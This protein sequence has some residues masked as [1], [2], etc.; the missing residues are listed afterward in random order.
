MKKY[1]YEFG[2]YNFDYY[3]R[4]LAKEID[5]TV[6]MLY[7]LKNLQDELEK[8]VRNKIVDNIF[9]KILNV[10]QESFAKIFT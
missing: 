2:L 3:Y 10:D 4:K 5:L 1:E 7:L 9:E 6:Q 8:E